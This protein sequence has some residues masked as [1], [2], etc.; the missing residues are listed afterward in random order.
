M[1]TEQTNQAKKIASKLES[2]SYL[3]RWN[4]KT[5]WDMYYDRVYR[6]L[7]EIQKIDCFAA[8][9]ANTVYDRAKDYA[10]QTRS[11]VMPKISSKQAWCLACA[12]VENNIEL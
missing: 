4:N 5:S 1:T 6:F 9:I 3:N 7:I 8:N 11:Y 10:K 2:V 12:A